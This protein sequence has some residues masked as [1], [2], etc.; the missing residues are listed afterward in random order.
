MFVP[1]HGLLPVDPFRA[2]VREVERIV[3]V[4]SDDGDS[5]PPSGNVR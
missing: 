2:L 4:E 1:S 5:G 3:I